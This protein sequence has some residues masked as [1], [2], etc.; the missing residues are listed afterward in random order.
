MEETKKSIVKKVVLFVVILGLFLL[1]MFGIRTFRNFSIIKDLQEKSEKYTNSTNYYV[2]SIT[3]NEDGSQSIMHI[4]QK[5]DK[6]LLVMESELNGE[7]AKMS[8]YYDG[9]TMDLF[10]DTSDGKS[11]VLGTKVNQSDSTIVSE[12][13]AEEDENLFL[14]SL[15]VKISEVEYQG[16]ACYRFEDFQSSSVLYEEGKNELYLDK[17]TGLSVKQVTGNTIVEKT[18]EFDTVDD[19]V[20]IKPDITQYEVIPAE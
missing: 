8:M 20:F 3:T 6:K 12:V 18:F 1:T 4:Y 2:K 13:G 17:D 15:L 14:L 5:G 9:E 10:A 16:K 19:S 11:A 7:P